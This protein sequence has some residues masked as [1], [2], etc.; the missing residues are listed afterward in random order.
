MKEPTTLNDYYFGFML[1]KS[2]EIEEVQ[3]REMKASSW[4]DKAHRIYNAIV[5]LLDNLSGNDEKDYIYWPDRTQKI[6]DFDSR[7]KSILEE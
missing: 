1:V 2:D 6:R 3:A 4:E 5:P 7:L